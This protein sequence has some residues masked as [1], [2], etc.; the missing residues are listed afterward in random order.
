MQ[1]REYY[2]ELVEHFFRMAVRHSRIKGKNPSNWFEFTQAWI[3]LQ[4]EEDRKFI[5]F[6]FDYHFFHTND[7]L[8]NYKSNADMTEKRQRLAVL[9]KR[10][11]E[12]GGLI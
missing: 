11:A 4:S 12:D 7:G 1:F 9:E 6:V 2:T 5:R 8:Y 10:F 3:D